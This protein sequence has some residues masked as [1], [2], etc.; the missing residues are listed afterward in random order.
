MTSLLFLTMDTF[1]CLP[2]SIVYCVVLP[3]EQKVRLPQSHNY[4]NNVIILNK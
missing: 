1:I 4:T 2:L 3:K